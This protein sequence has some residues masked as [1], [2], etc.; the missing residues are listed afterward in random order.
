MGGGPPPPHARAKLA[1]LL[2][3]R[4]QPVTSRGP[5][6]WLQMP[7]LF[8]TTLILCAVFLAVLLVWI[9]AT[10]IRQ[11]LIYP[12]NTRKNTE[13]RLRFAPGPRNPTLVPCLSVCSVDS[14]RFIQRFL[15]EPLNN[16]GQVHETHERPRKGNAAQRDPSFRGLPFVPFRVFRGLNQCFL[17]LAM[18]ASSMAARA[19]GASSRCERNGE[20]ALALTDLAA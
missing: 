4:L 13:S 18:A 3:R 19:F 20:P 8:H 15:R 2:P 9:V 12:R 16:P 10:P 6:A 1:S 5:S 14:I 17:R 11:P 7:G